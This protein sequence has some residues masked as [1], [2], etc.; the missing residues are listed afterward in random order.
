[1]L[2]TRSVLDAIVSNKTFGNATSAPTCFQT[3][4]CNFLGKLC[5]TF[6]R[7][8][9]LLP[10]AR[11]NPN[12]DRAEDEK[13]GIHCPFTVHPHASIFTDSDASANE[14]VET[15]FTTFFDRGIC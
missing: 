8:K 1:V 6:K 12:D 11:L 15:F 14:E 7:F 13:M 5:G 2:Q 10:L 3:L 9:Q 4:F